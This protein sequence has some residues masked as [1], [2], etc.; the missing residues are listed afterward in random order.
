M[1]TDPGLFRMF[2]FP[3]LLG[4]PETALESRDAVVLTQSTARKYFGDADP[5][6]RSLYFDSEDSDFIVTG[7]IADIP[8]NDL[9]ARLAAHNAGKGAKYTAPRR[10][11][12]LVYHEPAETKRAAFKR[13]KQIKSWP[14]AQK[15]ALVSGACQPLDRQTADQ[16]TNE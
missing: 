9:D 4:D 11:V 2:T 3:F 13:E 8:T 15:Q 14:R 5:L 7:V 16:P 1:L 10:P 6:G 12:S